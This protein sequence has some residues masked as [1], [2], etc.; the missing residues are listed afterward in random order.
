MIFQIKQGDANTSVILEA[1][2]DQ[3]QR[4][5]MAQRFLPEYK[6]GDKRI[7][8][9]NG[10]AFPYALARIP[11]E[12]EGRANLATG[13][14][15]VGVALTAREWEICAALAPRLKAMGLH[16]CRFGCDWGLYY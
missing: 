4:T 14:K 5:I 13:A 11:A 15:G 7:L 16:F 12:G 9:I 2:T 1:I 8:I 3:G 10:E 6:Q